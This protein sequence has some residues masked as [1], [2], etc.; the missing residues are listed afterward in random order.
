MRLAPRFIL[1]LSIFLRRRLPLRGFALALS[2]AALAGASFAQSQSAS[3]PASVWID[4]VQTLVARIVSFTPP[5][6]PLYLDFKNLSSVDAGE[7]AAVRRELGAELRLRGIHLSADSNAAVQAEVALSES[8]DEYLLVARLHRADGEQVAVAEGPPHSGG[9]GA[10]TGYS[11]ALARKAV[12]EQHQPILDFAYLPTDAAGGTPLLLILQ[13]DDLMLWAKPSAKWVVAESAPLHH[14]SPWP[15]DLRGWIDVNNRKVELPGVECTGDLAKP[16]AMQCAAASA[17]GKFPREMRQLPLAAPIANGRESG[18]SL[19]LDLNCGGGGVVLVTG[20]GDW[21]EPDSIQAFELED[22]ALVASGDPMPFPGP[23]LALWPSADL[24]S[25]RVV[26]R[27]LR[28]GM[29]EASVV[30]V[31]CGN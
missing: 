4:A 5:A 3:Q 11:F 9:K 19:L 8:T 23:V 28:T 17:S 21:T 20:S 25:A 14:A 29:Y 27:N 2:L 26:A 18:N 16:A 13:P 30:S 31:T 15:R 7:A 12:W 1:P 10:P 22:E 24:K 6:A